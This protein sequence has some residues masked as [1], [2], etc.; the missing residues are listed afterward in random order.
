MRTWADHA[1]VALGH[2]DGVWYYDGNAAATLADALQGDNLVGLQFHGGSYVLGTVK[3]AQ[4]GF[5]RI[6]RGFIEHSICPCVLALEYTL[7]RSGADN[8][9]QCFPL[10]VLEA[11]SAYYHL[12]HSLHIPPNR[13]V[14]IGDSAGAHLTLAMQRYL[15]ASRCMPSPCGVVLFS[16]WC[17]LTPNPDNAKHILGSLSIRDLFGPYFSP[18]LHAP[19]PHWPPTLIYSGAQEGFASSICALST[20]LIKAGVRVAAYEATNIRPRFSHDFLIFDIVNQQ[21]PDE[22]RTCWARIK[23]WMEELHV[24]PAMFTPAFSVEGR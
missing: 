12:L 22:V 10:Q 3:D 6:P 19:P 18:A 14:L 9:A 15:L 17:D 5:A 2:V 21:W 11:L 7:A 23:S 8:T 20:Q 1:G 24:Q 13:I 16:P 4:S